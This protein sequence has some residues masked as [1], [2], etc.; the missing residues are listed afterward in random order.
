MSSSRDGCCSRT[1]LARRNTPIVAPPPPGVNEKG[2]AAAR[3]GS[4]G[5]PVVLLRPRTDPFTSGHHARAAT[6]LL[7]AAV[8]LAA[9]RRSSRA[10]TVGRACRAGRAGTRGACVHGPFP[11]PDIYDAA[12]NFDKAAYLHLAGAFGAADGLRYRFGA[13]ASH[14]HTDLALPALPLARRSVCAETAPS[15][16]RRRPTSSIRSATTAR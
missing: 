9:R 14:Y 15:T 7:P 10:G 4:H 6:P 2:A 11:S 13:D 8:L 5:G 12:C 16:D 1:R 3:R